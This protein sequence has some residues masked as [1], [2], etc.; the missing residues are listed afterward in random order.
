MKTGPD[1]NTLWENLQWQGFDNE[2][3][4]RNKIMNAVCVGGKKLLS[5]VGFCFPQRGLC[6]LQSIGLQLNKEDLHMLV[7]FGANEI[8]L[9]VLMKATHWI[10]RE[11]S[12]SPY[13]IGLNS[14][15][16]IFNLSTATV[17]GLSQLRIRNYAKIHPIQ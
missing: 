13:I 16:L 1:G 10:G 5:S 17:F 8:G 4:Q 9:T 3:A 6:Y 7:H 2:H 14:L 15:I 11:L 12:S